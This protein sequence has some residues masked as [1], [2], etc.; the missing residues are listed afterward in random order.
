MKYCQYCGAQLEE[1]AKFCSGCGAPVTD[2]G[3]ASAQPGAPAP[4]Q[5]AAPA[6][7]QPAAPAPAAAKKYRGIAAQFEAIAAGK[8]PKASTFTFYYGFYQLLYHKSYRLF[9]YTYLPCSLLVCFAIFLLFYASAAQASGA[10]LTFSLLL[11]LIAMI[12]FVIVS[13]WMC[14]YYPQEL[15]KQ[16]QGNADNI[17]ASLLPPI[18]GG[19]ALVALVTVAIVIGL[20]AGSV[21]APAAEPTVPDSIA[22]EPLP[23]EPQPT[24]VPAPTEAPAVTEAPAE[25]TIDL[26]NAIP[27]DE[28]CWLAPADQPWLGAWYCEEEYSLMVFEESSAYIQYEAAQVSDGSYHI[29][30]SDPRDGIISEIYELSADRTTLTQKDGAGNYVRTYRRPRYA[31]AYTPLPQEFWGVYTHVEG[32]SYTSEQCGPKENFIVD[33]FRFG[34]CRYQ[35]LSD[36]GDGTYTFYHIV[37]PEGGYL[38]VSTGTY[39]GSPALALYDDAGNVT[40]VYLRTE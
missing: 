35:E 36:N 15:Y 22:G 19:L 17:P 13:I 25:N 14:R 27:S 26:S 5:P 12:G 1:D 6:P 10:L 21:S 3:G 29:Y 31:E 20:A 8:R 7:A 34:N 9:K 37:P 23:A 18:L 30:G 39:D 32:S 33:A 2:A 24:A 40:D 11:M 38:T 28:E 16:V 4:A